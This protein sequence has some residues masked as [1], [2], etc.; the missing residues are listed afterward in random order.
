MIDSICKS[1]LQLLVNS[2]FLQNLNAGGDTVPGVSYKFMVT[3]YDEVVTPYTSGF[4][5][6][7]NPLVQNVILQDLCA[8]D[9]SGHIILMFDPVVFHAANAFF[10][11][12]APQMVNC[13]S[14]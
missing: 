10:D 9:H 12:A 8:A 11:E 7:K 3:K 6:D 4:L 13:L 1:C 5:K 2:T 14:A